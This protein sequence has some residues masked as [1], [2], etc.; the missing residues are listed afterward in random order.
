M[1]KSEHAQAATGGP[2]AR[3]LKAY[4]PHPRLARGQGHLGNLQSDRCDCS[5]RGLAEISWSHVLFPAGP[6]E[7]RDKP[8]LGAPQAKGFATTSS[9]HFLLNR[10]AQ[11]TDLCQFVLL[12]GLERVCFARADGLVL[13]LPATDSPSYGVNGHGAC[14]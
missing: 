9:S 12:P 4:A 2:K 5:S 7:P 1:V 13:C 3:A 14:S 6:I 11:D 10:V 8:A